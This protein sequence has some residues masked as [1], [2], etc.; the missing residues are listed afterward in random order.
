MLSS[1]KLIQ[2]SMPVLVF[3]TELRQ[4]I[5]ASRRSGSRENRPQLIADGATHP[6]SA[7]AVYD[8]GFSSSKAIDVD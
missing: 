8:E 4:D 6:R 3:G 1:M 2:C 5:N 7:Q